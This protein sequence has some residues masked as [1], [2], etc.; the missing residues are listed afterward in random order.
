MLTF[1]LAFHDTPS[2]L[3]LLLT[4]HI[5]SLKMTS[6]GAKVTLTVGGFRR[7]PFAYVL[8]GRLCCWRDIGFGN[9]CSNGM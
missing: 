3:P 9:L 6:L 5:L 2:G 1:S 8:R 4:D 7:S